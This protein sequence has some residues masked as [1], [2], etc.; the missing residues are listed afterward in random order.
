MVVLLFKIDQQASC[1]ESG[2]TLLK[3]KARQV[4]MPIK[5]AQ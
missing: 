2:S 3:Q 1:P 5:K 4:C